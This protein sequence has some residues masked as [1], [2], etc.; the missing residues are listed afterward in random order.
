MNEPIKASPC[1][2]FVVDDEAGP[3]ELMKY[4]V[5]NSGYDV[6][7]LESGQACLDQLH[8]E[9]SAICLDLFMPGMNGLETLKRIKREAPDIPVIM[10]TSDDKIESAVESIKAGAYDYIVKPIDALRLQTTL[11]KAIEKY[12]LT[13][14]VKQL[15]SA[16]KSSYAFRNI[17]GVSPGMRK[18]FAQL[19][20]IGESSINVCIFGET[21]TG[22]EL[23]A[24]AVHYQNDQVKTPFVE[25]NCG[26]IPDS[27]QEAELFGYEKGAFTSAVDSKKG[28]L[29]LADGGTLFLDEVGEMTLATQVKLLRFLQ[30]RSFERVGGTRKI[31]VNLRVVCATNKN[32]E[33]AIE[34]GTFRDDLYYRLVV[35]PVTIPPLRERKEDIP[36]LCGYFLKKYQGEIQKPIT[37][38][39]PEAL[40]ALIRFDWPG[41][42]RQLENTIYRAMVSAEGKTVTKNSL[43][44]EVV[45]NPGSWPETMTVPTLETTSEQESAE[46]S[47]ADVSEEAQGIPERT[48]SGATGGLG[49]LDEA[50]KRAIQTALNNADGNIPETAKALEVSRA[51]LYRK[52]KKHGLT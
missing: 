19:E 24:R 17:I 51:T 38:I 45:E 9:P 14:Q 8:R 13:N 1:L 52:L 4:Q 6:C 15:R 11:Q 47:P 28:K 26:A 27:L 35:F 29:E 43:A 3:R 5:E 30:E 23:V 25:I 34:K 7:A 2:I 37:T 49:S 12:Q 21:G 39:E 18:L 36:Y 44:P 20:K 41:N 40:E 48:A 31:N 32:L 22:K 16:L 46:K 10:A 50:E 42:V 33:E